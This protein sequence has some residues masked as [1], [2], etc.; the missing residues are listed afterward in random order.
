M[1]PALQPISPESHAACDVS[2]ERRAETRDRAV[3]HIESLDTH[4]RLTRVL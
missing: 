1:Q 4:V 3:W 2:R